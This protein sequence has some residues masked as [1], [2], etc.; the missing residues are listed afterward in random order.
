MVSGDFFSSIFCSSKFT[1][2][3]FDMERNKKR[4]VSARVERVV[5]A[6]RRTSK[7]R[8]VCCGQTG[9]RSYQVIFFP[10]CW[11]EMSAAD[12]AQLSFGG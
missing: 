2:A 7:R 1:V 8:A 5:V 3:A 9:S 12:A 10:T 4:A 11:P 6:V